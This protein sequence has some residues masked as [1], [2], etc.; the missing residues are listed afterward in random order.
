MKSHLVA[1]SMIAQ[2]SALA[3]HALRTCR[4]DSSP[5]LY[6]AL[7]RLSQPELVSIVLSDCRRSI[8]EHARI[9]TLLLGR[10]PVVCPRARQ[11]PRPK[12][13]PSPI[14]VSVCANPRRPNTEA[15]DRFAR[16]FAP[17]RS[18]D[19]C[20]ARGATKRDVRTAIRNGWIEVRA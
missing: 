13:A 7:S 10:P 8:I 3:E 9:L 19:H 18:L 16:A 4:L 1:A 6:V 11:L 17:G 15:H 14:V 12:P 20:I 2:N 5:P